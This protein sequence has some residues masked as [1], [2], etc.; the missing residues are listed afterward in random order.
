MP[1]FKI[2][3]TRKV[4]EW[5]EAEFEAESPEAAQ[6]MYEDGLIDTEVVS[7]KITDEYD[8]EITEIHKES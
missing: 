6:K 2:E 1:L 8:D 7:H 3:F 5:H 4:T